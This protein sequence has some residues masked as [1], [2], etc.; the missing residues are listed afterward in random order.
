MELLLK[1]EEFSEL[2]TIGKLYIDGK[3]FCYTLEDKDRQKQCIGN[4]LPWS[5]NLKVPGKTAIAYGRYEIIINFSNRF[6]KP[7][8]LLLNVPDFLGVR[9]HSLNF[10]T[11]SAGCVGV[12]YTKAP[13]FIG[14]SKKA[15]RELFPII[16]GALKKGKVF[17]TITG[18]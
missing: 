13:D 3:Y 2:S 16:N 5:K 1:R 7:M 15:Y 9:I 12:G 17:I 11:E 10:A 4:I 8:P 18:V 6:Q 14:N